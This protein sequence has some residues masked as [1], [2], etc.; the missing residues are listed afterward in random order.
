METSNKFLTI[1]NLT[2]LM[3]I[4]STILAYYNHFDITILNILGSILFGTSIVLNLKGIIQLK[5]SSQQS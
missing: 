1:G 4:V 3:G 2:F 5:K